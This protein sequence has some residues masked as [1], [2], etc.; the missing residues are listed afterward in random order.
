M[1]RFSINKPTMVALMGPM[2]VLLL[3]TLAGSRPQTGTKPQPK[4]TTTATV[5]PQTPDARFR[6]VARPFLNS[7]CVPCHSGADA[8]GSFRADAAFKDQFNDR[9]TRAKWAEVVMC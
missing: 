6:T 8:K 3:C 1:N 2:V 5:A 4:V 7:Y 9:A